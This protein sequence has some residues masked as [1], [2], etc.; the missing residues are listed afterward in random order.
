MNSFWSLS[1]AD[2]YEGLR[3]INGPP[4]IVDARFD[5][6]VSNF[7]YDTTLQ[8]LALMWLECDCDKTVMKLKYNDEIKELDYNIPWFTPAGLQRGIIYNN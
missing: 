4:V 8:C 6:R 2:I 1:D 3:I 7:T 5:P